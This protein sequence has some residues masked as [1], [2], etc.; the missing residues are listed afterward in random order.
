MHIGL[1]WEFFKD[2]LEFVDFRLLTMEHMGTESQVKEKG[3]SRRLL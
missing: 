3:I 1:D 2:R